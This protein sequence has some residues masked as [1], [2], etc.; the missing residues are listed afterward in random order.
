MK[1]LKMWLINH[2]LPVWA[3]EELLAE[4]E[5]LRKQITELQAVIDQKN[6]YISGLEV[7][8]KAMRRITVYAGEGRK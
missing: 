7:G 2:F 3:K 6:A 4:N 1:K 5:R 8:I